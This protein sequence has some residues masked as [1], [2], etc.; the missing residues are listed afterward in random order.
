MT[1]LV[2]LAQTPLAAA[3]GDLWP[4]FEPFVAADEDERTWHREARRRRLKLLR[5]AVLPAKCEAAGGGRSLDTVR[6]EY[7]RS[8]DRTRDYPYALD[9]FP[10]DF[11]PWF[12]AGRRVMASDIGATR[13]RQA[14]FVAVIEQLRPRRVL[15]IGCGNGIN[16]L[17]LAGR[18]PEIAFHGL[19][20]TASG[21]AAAHHFQAAHDRLPEAIE[22]YAP[23]PL[24]DPTAFQKVAFTR[25]NAAALPFPDGAFDLVYTS[26]ALEQ[27]EVVRQE[28][29]AEMARVTAGWTFNI[30][31]FADVNDSFWSKLYVG[32]RGYFRG[33]IEE[34]RRIG[35]EPQWATMDFPQEL[36]LKSCAVLAKKRG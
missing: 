12:A 28:A 22:A 25:G 8:W 7:E 31:P 3:T 16:L 6:T 13:F 30:E 17:L 32:Q 18:F 10:K 4:L 29:L 24:A 26:L 35:L 1:T 19:E 27:M 33:R 23:R 5:R 14:L 34:L 36:F 20:L 9:D 2:P 21:V 15:E 11:Q